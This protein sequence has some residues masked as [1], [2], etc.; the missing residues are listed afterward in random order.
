MSDEV[1]IRKT[2]CWDSARTRPASKSVPL[3]AVVLNMRE[4]GDVGVAVEDMALAESI[5]ASAVAADST[6]DPVSLCCSLGD[7]TPYTRAWSYRPCD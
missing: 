6:L 2:F 1:G 3:R 5:S 7:S 4:Q